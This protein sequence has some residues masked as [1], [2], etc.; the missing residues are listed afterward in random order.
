M[1]HASSLEQE[2]ALSSSSNLQ[3]LK[4]LVTTMC[5]HDKDS[6]LTLVYGCAAAAAA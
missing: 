4:Q 2:A 6:A 3:V 1:H 5:C